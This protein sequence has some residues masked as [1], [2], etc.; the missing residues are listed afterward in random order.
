MHTHTHTHTNTLPCC[1]PHKLHYH[2]LS[3]S[4][5]L[6]AASASAL[7]TSRSLF[8]ISFSCWPK[9]LSTVNA[10]QH[11]D[12]SDKTTTADR[13][14]VLEKATGVGTVVHETHKDVKSSAD[15][16]ACV[17]RLYACS[18][19]VCVHVYVRVCCLGGGGVM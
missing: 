4:G 11:S 10:V 5:S 14:E 17:C 9:S 13:N 3:A 1:L 7:A 16:S 15:F 12:I 8:S 2:L 6:L 19:C 18:R